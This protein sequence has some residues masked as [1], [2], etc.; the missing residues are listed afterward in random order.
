[1]RSPAAALLSQPRVAPPVDGGVEF[2]RSTVGMGREA[3]LRRI[4]GLARSDPAA[5]QDR[6]NAAAVYYDGGFHARSHAGRGLSAH[7]NQGVIMGDRT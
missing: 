4:G 3:A 1:M 2:C 6:F 7:A 5:S